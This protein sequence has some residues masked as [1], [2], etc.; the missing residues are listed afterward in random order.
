MDYPVPEASRANFYPRPRVEGD[1]VVS[2]VDRPVIVNF[3]PRPRVEGDQSV[4]I[5]PLLQAHFYPRPRVE[6][7]MLDAAFDKSIRH[8][9]PRPRVEGDGVALEKLTWINSISTHALA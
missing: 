6:G 3:Y 9:Y 8:F 4:L 2:D 5:I 1:I 7:D